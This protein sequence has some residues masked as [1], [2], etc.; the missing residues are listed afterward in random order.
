VWIATLPGEIETIAGGDGSEL[1]WISPAYGA[2]ERT[3]TLRVARR[4]ATPG[5]LVTAIVAAA[6]C[7]ALEV[8]PV[9]VEG[10]AD[11]TAAALRLR[12]GEVVDTILF[13]PV[14][15]DASPRRCGSA[16]YETD[17]A[18][19]WAHTASSKA[20]PRVA[21]VDGRM[22]RMRDGRTPID[23][24]ESVACRDAVV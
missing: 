1:G 6:A 13:G 12:A 21:I 4:L 9:T 5:V 23:L 14:T 18:M 3:T 17:A 22:A 16:G 19:L 10:A 2:L 15:A 24:T 20:A 7:P 8:L 11:P